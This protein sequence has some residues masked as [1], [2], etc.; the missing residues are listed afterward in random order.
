MSKSEVSM[1]LVIGEGNVSMSVGGERIEI[2]VAGGEVHVVRDGV[3]WKRVVSDRLAFEG[4][5]AKMRRD[6][7]DAERAI[8]ESEKLLR[9]EQEKVAILC[10][11]LDANRARVVELTEGIR[12]AVKSYE[13]G[14]LYDSVI[15]GLRRLAML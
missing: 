15:G 4:A 2:G 6:L 14:G 5:A 8:C 3:D 13:Q 7:V 11:A 10:E 1:G 9:E 12:R